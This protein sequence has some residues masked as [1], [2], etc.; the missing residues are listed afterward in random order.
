MPEFK[1]LWE[2]GACDMLT[3]RKNQTICSDI[4]WRVLQGQDRFDS[5]GCRKRVTQMSW[6][7]VQG[8]RVAAER[9]LREGFQLLKYGDVVPRSTAENSRD[10]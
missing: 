3:E 1:R 2:R 5:G 8:E 9:S 10:D 6:A 7:T 4:C